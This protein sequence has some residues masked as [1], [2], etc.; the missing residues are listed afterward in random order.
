MR[1]EDEEDDD[2]DD[3]DDDDYDH[4][5]DNDRYQKYSEI[6]Y[7][8][9]NIRYQLGTVLVPTAHHTLPEQRAASFGVQ[10]LGVG[11]TLGPLFC[12]ETCRKTFWER[13]PYI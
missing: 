5:D 3:D 7:Q 4:D 10:L 12:W 2:D 6:I 8:T 1:D 13:D 11:R 9:S